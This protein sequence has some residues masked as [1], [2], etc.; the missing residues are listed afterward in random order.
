MLTGKD[1][2]TSMSKSIGVGKVNMTRIEEAEK[3]K[4]GQKTKGRKHKRRGFKKRPDRE[5]RRAKN[6]AFSSHCYTPLVADEGED[7]S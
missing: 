5:Q 4:Q 2:F 6:V 1:V 7:E 3:R